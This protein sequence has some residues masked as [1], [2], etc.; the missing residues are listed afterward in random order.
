MMTW[1]PSRTE[2]QL[3]RTEGG[4]TE[5]IPYFDEL[6]IEGIKCE[7]NRLKSA[8]PQLEK[9]FYK[10]LSNRVT[11]RGYTD[12]QLHDAVNYVIDNCTY[13]VPTIANIMSFK[14]NVKLKTYTEICTMVETHG[15]EIWD[16][17]TAITLPGMVKKVWVKTTDAYKYNLL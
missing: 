6:T 12:K 17:Y 16:E 9:E 14:N 8:F 13:P 1:T 3:I 5:L 7:F 10:V 15:R 11:E 2:S 4:G